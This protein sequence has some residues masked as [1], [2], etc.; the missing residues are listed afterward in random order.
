MRSQ[1]FSICFEILS[2]CNCVC[3]T[4]G[5]ENLSKWL[6]NLPWLAWTLEIDQDSHL[7]SSIKHG[8]RS[9]HSNQRIGHHSIR[10][11]LLVTQEKHEKP[12]DCGA[13]VTGAAILPAPSASANLTSNL[14]RGQ[15]SQFKSTTCKLF[16]YVNLCLLIFTCRLESRAP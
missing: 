7:D 14:A 5:P 1:Y 11:S 15:T 10:G 16:T 9:L 6:Q 8:K 2:A 3:L 13:K 4:G 12:S